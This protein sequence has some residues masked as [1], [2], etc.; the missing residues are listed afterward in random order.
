MLIHL[1]LTLKTEQIKRPK[2][3]WGNVSRS[4]SHH[5]LLQ[6]GTLGWQALQEMGLMRQVDTKQTQASPCRIFVCSPLS[7][8][9]PSFTT[10]PLLIWTTRSL[11]TLIFETNKLIHTSVEIP[12]GC[13]FLHRIHW[14]SPLSAP[15]SFSNLYLLLP[16]SPWW[17]AMTEACGN[18]SVCSGRQA[19]LQG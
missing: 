14:I 13:S 12:G 17:P 1:R 16:S 15:P 18:R 6:R 9:L 3:G 19:L 7:V 5:S 10:S 2:E 8:C 11:C 4:E